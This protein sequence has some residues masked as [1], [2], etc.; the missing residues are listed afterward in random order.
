MDLQVVHAHP[1]YNVAGGGV[2]T[3]DRQEHVA[4]GRDASP[5]DDFVVN[6]YSVSRVRKFPG[7]KNSRA[8]HQNHSSL[9]FYFRRVHEAASDAREGCSSHLDF[10]VTCVGSAEVLVLEVAASARL[11]DEAHPGVGG[12]SEGDRGQSWADVVRSKQGSS[13]AEFLEFV[14]MSLHRSEVGYRSG[15]VVTSLVRATVSASC[16][17]RRECRELVERREM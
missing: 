17:V 15:V 11:A 13:S 16:R 14:C 8:C 5:G 10:D 1:Q 7:T 3:V 4:H 9:G 2:G 6:V 12:S